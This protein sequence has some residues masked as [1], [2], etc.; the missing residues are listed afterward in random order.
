[1]CLILVLIA[2]NASYSLGI[3]S[4]L[5]SPEKAMDGVTKCVDANGIL[6]TWNT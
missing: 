4:G 1:L 3:L 5:T 2:T 6:W